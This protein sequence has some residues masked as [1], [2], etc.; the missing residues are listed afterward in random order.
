MGYMLHS[1]LAPYEILKRI[2][3]MRKIIFQTGMLSYLVM[4]LS[5]NID[6]RL[7]HFR[8]NMRDLRAFA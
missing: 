4:L 2:A 3:H 5:D 8:H 7:I 1:T 6:L